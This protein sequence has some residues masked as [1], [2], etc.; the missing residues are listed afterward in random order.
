MR[1]SQTY[2]SSDN[3]KM[4]NNS[5]LKEDMTDDPLHKDGYWTNSHVILKLE[6]F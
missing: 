4:L 2:M 5:D 6:Y 3:A 1:R